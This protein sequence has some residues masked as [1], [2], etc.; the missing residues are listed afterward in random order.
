M[1]PQTRRKLGPATYIV[2]DSF[3]FDLICSLCIRA[4]IDDEEKIEIKEYAFKYISF[5]ILAF[6]LFVQCFECFLGLIVCNYWM[7]GS[8][9]KY[10]L[11]WLGE[12]IYD[13][14]F[15]LTI[16]NIQR[17]LINSDHIYFVRYKTVKLEKMIRT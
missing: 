9:H 11:I 14:A 1:F 8:T 7:V 12:R 17:Y 4:Y 2:G 16:K 3:K 10:S 5:P 15:N 6:C 13:W